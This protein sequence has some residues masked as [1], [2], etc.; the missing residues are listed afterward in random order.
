M[1]KKLIKKMPFIEMVQPLKGLKVNKIT[2][3]KINDKERVTIS[4]NDK[5]GTALYFTKKGKFDG[6]GVTTKYK[7]K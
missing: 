2:I 5:F 1:P 7:G 3:T 4:F 6:L